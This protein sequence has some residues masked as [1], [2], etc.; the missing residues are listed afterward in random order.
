MKQ[1]IN[2]IIDLLTKTASNE[3][4]G[5]LSGNSGLSLFYYYCSGM[6]DKKYLKKL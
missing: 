3:S 4:L 2:S 6:V 5:L 1:K